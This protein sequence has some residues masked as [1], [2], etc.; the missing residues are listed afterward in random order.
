MQKVIYWHRLGLEI[1]Q[2]NSNASPVL[3]KE[4]KSTEIEEIKSQLKYLSG[5]SVFLLLSNEFSYL[6]EKTVTPPLVVDNQFKS[7]LLDLIK[8]DIPEDFSNFNWDYQIKDNSNNQQKI[9]IFAPIKEIQLLVQ[10]ISN[11]LNIKFE[12]IEPESIAII[13]DPNP[14]IGIT[15][16]NDIKGKDEENLNLF[17]IPKIKAHQFPIK[18]ILLIIFILIILFL[19]FIFIKPKSIISPSS[20][21]VPTISSSTS[22]TISSP[23]PVSTVIPTIV[24]KAL[25]DLNVMVQ[26][27]TT[28]PGLASKTATILKN[29]GLNQVSTGNADNSSYS[30]NKLTFKNDSL[31]A[32]YQDKFKSLFKISDSNINVD[33]LVTYDVI[34][35]LGSN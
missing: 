6:F 25:S 35:I 13:R 16:K 11:I 12:V 31:K 26:N 5:Q 30:A 29:N 4:I 20:E 8:S 21:A 14:I 7:K 22:T 33:N 27:G 2:V 28:Q 24:V 32:D 17:I 19:I 3:E 23:T 10:E 34:F 1:Y 9:L 18:R 15:K